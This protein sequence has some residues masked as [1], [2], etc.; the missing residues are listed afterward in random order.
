M[1]LASMITQS[2][3]TD[4]ESERLQI[5]ILRA[6]RVWQRVAQV[7]ALNALAENFTMAGL[8]PRHPDATETQLRQLLRDRRLQML[9]L[10]AIPPGGEAGPNGAP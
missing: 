6:M 7:E 1:A 4:P 8:R 9:G 5:R 10:S 3:D 2:P